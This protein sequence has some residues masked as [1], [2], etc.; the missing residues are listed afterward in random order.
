[1]PADPKTTAERPFTPSW[2]RKAY[3]GMC[4][5]EWP[6]RYPSCPGCDCGKLNRREVA[7]GKA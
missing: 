2:E 1:M 7:D 5:V 6:Q 3:C 4:S